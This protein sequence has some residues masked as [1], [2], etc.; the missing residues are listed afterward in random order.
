MGVIM[1]PSKYGGVLELQDSFDR[2]RD[3]S[4]LFK[5]AAHLAW[6]L[7]R[8]MDIA[9]TVEAELRFRDRDEGERR[10]RQEE[11]ERAARDKETMYGSEG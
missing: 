10:R 4:R 3:G 9:D 5:D 11:A 7:Y 8:A 6:L 2:L 1:C